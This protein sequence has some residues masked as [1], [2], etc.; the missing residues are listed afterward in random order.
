MFELLGT[1]AG[2]IPL[3]SKLNE[4]CCR[5]ELMAGSL[6]LVLLIKHLMF[7]QRAGESRTIYSAVWSDITIGERLMSHGVAMLAE[8][9]TGRK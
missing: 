5:P 6:R 4:D 7:G 3:P 1:P 8:T 2:L 9:R